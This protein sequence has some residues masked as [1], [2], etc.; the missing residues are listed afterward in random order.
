MNP[1]G[2]SDKNDEGN[3]GLNSVRV[4]SPVQGVF[5]LVM[6][7]YGTNIAA[8]NLMNPVS[9]V[10][11]TSTGV[12]N[13]T[14]VIIHV[15][16]GES[17]TMNPSSVK[18]SNY[19]KVFTDSVHDTD[20]NAQTRNI[21]DKMLL[22]MPK[23]ALIPTKASPNDSNVDNNLSGIAS[24]SSP[25]VQSVDIITKSTSYA[26]AAGVSTKEQPKVNSNIH[27]LVAGPVFN[28]VNIS[29]PS[30]VVKKWMFTIGIP[31]LAE[32]DF[33]KETICVEYE[34]RPPR[35]D[36]CKIF[37]HVHDHC[38]KK[39]MSPPIVTTLNI[40][41]PT[42]EK[43]NDG[44]QTVG[45]K[46]KRKGESKSTNGGQFAGLSVKQTVR[47]EPK[48]TTSAL[49]KGATNVSN[50]SKSSSMLKT[51]DTYRKKDKFTTSNSFSALNDD[52]VKNV[53]DESANLSPNTK[54]GGRSSFTAVAGYHVY[55]SHL[56]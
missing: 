42:V 27:P 52:G 15:T 7:C 21:K 17:L 19:L 30:K 54:T 40:V 38:P 53:Y 11:N 31:S 3:E 47:Y 33:I 29:I 13:A 16:L 24:P 45:K 51:M 20:P 9:K 55:L 43:S 18:V 14:S 46:K 49:K 10:S 35:C 2:G 1:N 36:E 37:G 50:P 41:A 44:F 8:E 4:P 12:S 22:I 48:A 26:G 39:V 6:P 34:W 25:V 28:G 32:D 23:G 56:F 5:S